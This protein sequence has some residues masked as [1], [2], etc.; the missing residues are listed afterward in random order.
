MSNKKFIELLESLLEDLS[1]VVS[2]SPVN[3][4]KVAGVQGKIK[5]ALIL[6]REE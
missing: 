6:L 5:A 2:S 1:W 3:S 4:E